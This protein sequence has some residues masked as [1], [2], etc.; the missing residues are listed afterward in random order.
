MLSRIRAGWLLALLPLAAC[1]A[2]ARAQEALPAAQPATCFAECASSGSSADGLPY[3]RLPFDDPPAERAFRM[4]WGIADI[5]GYTGQRM[6]PNG[7]IFHPDYG[8]NLDF[9]IWLCPE[10][11]L[12]LFDQ[13]AFWMGTTHELNFT[14]REFDM[15][16]GVAWNWYGQFEARAYG[17]SYN[18]LNRGVNLANPYGYNDGF[19]ME[20]RY[21]LNPIYKALGTSDYDQAR[22]TFLSIG[23]MPTKSLTGADGDTFHPGLFARA[24][25][26]CNL[27]KECAYAYADVTFYTQQEPS[28]AGKLLDSD[29]GVAVRP[30][31][32]IPRLEFRVGCLDIYDVQ[33]GNARPVGYFSIR[34]IF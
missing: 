19:A 26:T 1:P 32:Q 11:G 6:A 29:T 23:W 27:V 4:V 22:A 9:N 13:S 31:H 17:Y 2:L 25:L 21:Y 34:Y 3:S 7:V 8:V 15:N 33:V 16:I 10:L 24:Y 5:D 20:N 14:K 28:F 30:C 12:Y 18:N